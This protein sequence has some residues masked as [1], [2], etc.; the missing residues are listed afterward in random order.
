MARTRHAGTRI[1]VTSFSDAAGDHRRGERRPAGDPA[2]MAS[3]SHWAD[4]AEV[5]SA[6]DLDRLEQA[7][8]TPAPAEDAPAVTFN[9]D[10]R[11]GPV[12]CNVCGALVANTHAHAA[13]HTLI[14]NHAT[15]VAR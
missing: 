11:L 9:G 6:A 12:A 3:P 7:L 15:R 5:T 14:G 1:A 8:R 4:A 2:V 13:W 10:Q